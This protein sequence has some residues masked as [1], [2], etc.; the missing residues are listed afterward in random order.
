M[1][2]AR[3]RLSEADL[4]RLSKHETPD[5]RATAT[6][7]LCRT[8][9]R[10]PLSE[11]DRAAAQDILRILAADAV[12]LVRRSL[13]VTL[14]SSPLLPR[15]VAMKLA[16]D[17]EAVALPVLAES[18][19][20]T[21]EDLIEIVRR[22]APERQVAIAQRPKVA[23]RVTGAIIAFGAEPAVAAVCAND[24]AE[25]PGQAL[26]LALQRFPQSP[27]VAQAVAARSAVPPHI[28]EQLVGR[29]EG[30]VRDQ[31]I[32]R[33]GLSP[34]LS[35]RLAAGAR[36][37][38]TAD[39]V[40]QIADARDLAAFAAHL[41]KL[42]RLNA[43]LLLRAL[44]RGQMS[45]FE[46]GLAELA[47]V[48]HSRV[49]IMVHDAGPLGLRAVCERAGLPTRLFAAFRTGV[50]VWR[51]LQHEGLV[52]DR[53]R[54]QERMLQRFLTQRPYAPREDLEY[55]LERLDR[56]EDDLRPRHANAA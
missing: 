30:A 45:F 47:G 27:A 31:L 40:D 54:L 19:A 20:F 4:R 12:E 23:A 22:G 38:A 10:M 29:L 37:R 51:S 42:K 15:D 3:P 16:A 6:H 14:R 9:D 33:H 26:S 48:P 25:T 28:V 2:F 34:E 24:H 11:R 32:K 1:T 52:G 17:V 43:S 50:D 44:A 35:L 53:E 18:P 56:R 39:I 41:N 21:D 8:L 13:S 5:A 46:H 49:C 36:E 55:L 7:K